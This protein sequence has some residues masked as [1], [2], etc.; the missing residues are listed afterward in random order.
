MSSNNKPMFSIIIP[1]YL[2][3]NNLPSTIKKLQS[4]DKIIID[5]EIE[6]IFIDDGSPDQSLNLLLEEQKNDRR[7]K[8]IKLSR[9]FGSMGAIQAGLSTASGDCIG[10]ISADLQD[11]PELF[12][13]MLERWKTGKKIVIAVRCGREDSL[14]RKVSSTIYHYLLRKYAIKNYPQGGFDFVLIDRQVAYEINQIGEK[15]TN[16]FSLIFWLGFERDV[17]LYVRQKRDKGK[18]AWTFS[19]KVKLVID[20]F[21][22]FSYVPIRMMSIVGL[23]V[24]ILSFSYGTF[25]IFNY[26]INGIRV[27][28]WSSLVVL[29]TFLLGMIMLMLGIIGEYLWRILD[30]TRKRPP[31]I[32]DRYYE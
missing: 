32:I 28:G 22:S 14:Y 1:V 23:V 24:A 17:I 15:N 20:S 16:L 10:I 8:I 4:L 25:V 2:N 29:I 3:E 13:E 21:V 18:S 9:N 31:F 26:L 19:K 6:F 7:I 30:E 11:P 5:F 12:K 27:E